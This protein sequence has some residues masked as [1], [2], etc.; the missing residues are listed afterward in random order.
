MKRRNRM[1]RRNVWSPRR[2][3]LG[4]FSIGKQRKRKSWS[5]EQLEDRLVFSAQPLQAEHG[6]HFQL[7]AGRRGGSMDAGNA[8]G[9]AASSRGNGSSQ[10]LQLTLSLPNDPLFASQWHLLNTGQEVGSPEFPPLYGVAGQDINV[11]PVWNMG[12]TG[13]GVLVAVID[14]GV[15]MSHPD[16]V[17]NIHPTLRFNAITGTSNPSPPLFDPGSSHGTAVAG[18]IAATW[19]N[20]GTQVLDINGDPVFDVDGNPV[21]SGGGSGVAPNATIVPIRLIGE[22]IQRPGGAGCVSVCASK[23]RRYHEQQ[24]GAGRSSGLAFPEDP[25]IMQVLRDSV[26]FGRDGLGMIN[27]FASGNGGGPTYSTWIRR[28]RQLGQFGVLSV[29]ELALHDCR[30][31]CRP[32]RAVPECR[33]H[34]HHV[35]RSRPRGAGGGADWLERRP[36]RRGRQW[37]GKR[38]LD[39]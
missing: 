21:Y 30:D 16:L 19:N 18:L 9:G 14:T 6:Q 27:V 38:N 36:E 15:Q 11:V 2:K 17:A 29:A 24:L 12:F 37:P 22:R 5:F 8:M 13:E 23:R 33:W 34:V 20:L 39:D 32:R 28:R 10:P 4:L 35:S 1:G 31:R 3:P 7:N 26:I 25:A